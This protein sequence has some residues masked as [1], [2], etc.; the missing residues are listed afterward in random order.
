MNIE[1]ELQ[2][3]R[4]KA[5]KIASQAKQEALTKGRPDIARNIDM[6]A[7]TAP[8]VKNTLPPTLPSLPPEKGSP[9]ATLAIQGAGATQTTLSSLQDQLAK[10]NKEKEA[11]LQQQQGLLDKLT[12]RQ[13]KSEAE[14]LKE[15][16]GEWAIPQ[17]FKQI[18]DITQSSLPLYK[19]LSDL[20]TA[21]T[22]ELNRNSQRMASTTAIREEE[23][24]IK[25]RYAKMKAPIASELHAY[26]A[27]IQALQGNLNTAQQLANNA[28][29]A[30]TYDEERDYNRL[31][32]FIS[33]NQSFINGLDSDQ[34]YIM[35]QAL[36]L[37]RRKLE[38]ARQDKTNV[39]NLKL[40]YPEAGI[41][42]TDTLEEATK[43]ASDW[44]ANQ[45]ATEKASDY[46]IITDNQGNM[47]R[48][49]KLTG[50]KTSLGIQKGGKEII[51]QS[52]LNKLATMGVPNDVA[53]TM[54]EDVNN[55]H[56][57]D[58]IYQGMISSGISS[59][60]AV[61]YI[62]TFRDVMKMQG[63]VSLQTPTTIKPYIPPE[64]SPQNSKGT[65]KWW[66]PFTWF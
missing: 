20:D 36:N 47:W 14:L 59:D 54:Q 64:T 22:N 4:E 42:I 5:S 40:K 55:G 16:F 25:E 19:Q 7:I 17:T 53:L 41:S 58:E 27:Q 62:N 28:V 38:E 32:D 45:P 30:A 48:V 66:N 43:K 15:Q 21:E 11:L 2:T 9:D 35:T 60:K 57:W 6:M 51:S 65:F 1:Q 34:K 63:V 52:T 61:N 50:E 49:N 3:I 37:Q 29:K 8:E 31:K 44:T 10:W 24:A 26:A 13:P 33:I 23:N 56:S 46:Q 39:M 18:Q 12:N